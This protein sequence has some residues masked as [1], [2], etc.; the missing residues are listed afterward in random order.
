MLFEVTVQLDGE[1]KPKI[2]WMKPYDLHPVYDI[3][4]RTEKLDHPPGFRFKD[5]WFL[6]AERGGK[7]LEW[8]NASAVDYAGE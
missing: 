6:V 5:T 3:F 1:G 2:P 4:K 7:R 8:V